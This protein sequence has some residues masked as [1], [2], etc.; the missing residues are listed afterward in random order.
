MQSLGGG[1][2]RQADLRKGE[3]YEKN[4][5]ARKKKMNI[6][7]PRKKFD[8]SFGLA[9]LGYYK[10]TSDFLAEELKT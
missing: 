10:K 4:V 6:R 8:K 9:M 7:I 3:I 5:K 1:G 2:K